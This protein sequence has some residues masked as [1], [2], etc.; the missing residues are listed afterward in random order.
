MLQN[1]MLTNGT[2][3]VFM[4]IRK[5]LNIKHFCPYNTLISQKMDILLIE[6]S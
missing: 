1:R 5:M 2:N 6:L 4:F 3:V